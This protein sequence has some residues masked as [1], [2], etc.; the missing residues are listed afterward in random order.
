MGRFHD[1]IREG[2]K[3]NDND[4][5][6]TAKPKATS[7]V[8][9]LIFINLIAPQ[10]VYNWCEGDMDEVYAQLLACAPPAAYTLAYMLKEHRFDAMGGT[11]TIASILSVLLVYSFTN[12]SKYIQLKDSVFSLCFGLAF[13]GLTCIGK[14]D[15][16]WMSNRQTNGPEDKAELDAKYED[17]G[18]RANSHFMCVV[19]G[20]GLL[21]ESAVRVGLIF[22]ISIEAMKTVSPALLVVTFGL[23][24]LWTYFHVKK[25]RSEQAQEKKFPTAPNFVDPTKC[26]E[27][28]LD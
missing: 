19:W 18:I 2:Q 14:E 23:L 7:N 20:V 11:A 22:A 21:V 10:I 27:I 4:T 1:R 15:L 26:K 17:P 16:I 12:D 6:A 8:K 28:R 25:L 24:G 13:W 5:A 3:N 9:L